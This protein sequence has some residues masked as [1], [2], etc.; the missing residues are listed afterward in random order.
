MHLLIA[1]LG[2]FLLIPAALAGIITGLRDLASS[3]NLITAHLDQLIMLGE[4]L[5]PVSCALAMI[6][7]GT[8]A[9]SAGFWLLIRGLQFRA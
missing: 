6:T 9:L 3:S 2:L 4:S 1:L 8:I 7:G 5:W